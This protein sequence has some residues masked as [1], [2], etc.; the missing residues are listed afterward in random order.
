[1]SPGS[2]S[3]TLRLSETEL[4]RGRPAG[5]KPMPKAEQEALLA[6]AKGIEPLFRA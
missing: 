5:F 1:L 6:S 2:S 4:Y 3:L